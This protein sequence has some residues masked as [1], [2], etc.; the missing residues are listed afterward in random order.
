[1]FQLPSQLRRRF[2]ILITLYPKRLFKVPVE[3]EC[4]SPDVFAEKSVKEI[5][6]LQTWEGNRKR[7]LGD[8]FKIKHG[9]DSSSEKFTIQICG[10]VSEVRKIGAKMSMGN[11]II[12]GD[13]GMHLGEEMNGGAITVTGNADSWTGSMMKKGTIEIKGNAG[14][15]IGASYRGSTRGMSGGKIIIHGNAGY[16]V[17]CFMRK[18]LI[19]VY[20]N[21]GQFTGIHMRKGTIFIQGNSEGRTGAQMINGKIVVCGYIPS[22][23]PTFTIDDI[24]PKVKV[25]GEKVEGPFY[26][27]IG[28]LAD[29][30]NGKLFVSK[31]KNM[32]LSFYEEYL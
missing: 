2:K 11:I 22:I 12:E 21:T 26:R 8:L 17:G 23:L 9:T 20:G 4:I 31:T 7:T 10:D 32:H 13:A 30:G 25:N 6:T 27:F 3:A 29:R 18:G 24:R 1:M 16:E 19:R 15:Y 28:D 14:D 5:A